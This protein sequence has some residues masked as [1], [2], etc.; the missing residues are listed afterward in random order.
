MHLDSALNTA[1]SQLRPSATR[2]Y[3]SV[4]QI[5]VLFPLR[6]RG[7]Q[8]RPSAT[9]LC[10]WAIQIIKVFPIRR[11]GSQLRPLRPSRNP[12]TI[13]LKRDCM[14]KIEPLIS[15][16]NRYC[17]LCS[18]CRYTSDLSFILVL[19][20]ETGIRTKIQRKTARKRIF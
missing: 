3:S 9:R 16:R 18:E 17:T 4:I 6:K 11:R 2:L 8:L 1:G 19:L 13:I 10:L 15:V 14:K 20:G 5:C 12:A 7:S